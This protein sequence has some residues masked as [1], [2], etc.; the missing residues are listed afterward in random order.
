MKKLTII[1]PAFNEERTIQEVIGKVFNQP[2]NNCEKEVIIV[3]DGS[4][5]DTN[6]ILTNLKSQLDFILLTHAKNLGKGEAIKTALNLASGDYFLIQDA[7]LEY[8]PADW[9]ILLEKVK[10]STNII[11][12]GSRELS[13]QRRGYAHCVL[14][15]KLL[16]ALIN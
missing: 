4:T 14:G 13:P 9:P 2:L 10:D 6:K 12:F 16:T 7:D 11:V 8:N 3:D 5:D 15:V 1:I